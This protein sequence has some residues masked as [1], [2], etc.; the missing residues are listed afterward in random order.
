M[1]SS[2]RIGI[3]CKVD[4]WP[5]QMQT[6]LHLN[7]FYQHDP[8]F[9]MPTTTNLFLNPHPLPSHFEGT[10]PP[11]APFFS[12]SSSTPCA[13]RAQGAS[14]GHALRGNLKIPGNFEFKILCAL[15]KISALSKSFSFCGVR[16]FENLANHAHIILISRI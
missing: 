6:Q 7:T 11:P 14:Q 13:R 10:R 5:N 8:R 4:M 9:C 12:R 15:F 1:A 2:L 16:K 3:I